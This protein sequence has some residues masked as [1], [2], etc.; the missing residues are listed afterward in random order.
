M[1]FGVCNNGESHAVSHYDLRSASGGLLIIAG[2][3]FE[4][5][6]RAGWLHV[7]L[8]I[9]TLARERCMGKPVKCKRAAQ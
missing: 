6:L 3:M 1:S 7:A 5:A 9:Y 2:V 8:Y 4:A